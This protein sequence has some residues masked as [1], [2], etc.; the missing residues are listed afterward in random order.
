M[1]RDDFSSI[2]SVSVGLSV[3]L[4][5]KYRRLGVQALEG[6]QLWAGRVGAKLLAYDDSSRKDLAIENVRRLLERDRVRI[7]FG[8]YSS[9]LAAAVAEVAEAQGRLMW[10]YGGSSDEVAGRWVVSVPSPASQYFR[11]LPAWLRQNAPE[12]SAITIM[13]SPH[14]SFAAHVTRGLIEEAQALGFSIRVL[15]LDAAPPRAAGI[16]V[17]AGSFEEEVRALRSRPPARIVAAVAAGIRAFYDELGPAAEEVIGPSQ[18]EPGPGS[19]TFVEAF[20]QRFGHAP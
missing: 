4:S 3:S 17:L 6:V 10:N 12:A 19:E 13:R 20:E 2:N 8:P 9:G 14:G 16:I 11:G 1:A 5:G 18:W 15:P 7:L